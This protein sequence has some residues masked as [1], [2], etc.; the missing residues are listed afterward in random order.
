MSNK[1]VKT[2][3]DLKVIVKIPKKEIKDT[4]RNLS[5]QQLKNYNQLLHGKNAF[6]QEEWESLSKKQRWEIIQRQ[7]KVQKVLNWWKQRI[8]NSLC[9]YVLDIFQSKGCRPSM[10]EMFRGA[11][12]ATNFK[13]RL[14]FEQL[15]ITR[16]MIVEK[17]IEKKFIDKNLNILEG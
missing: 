3:D 4:Y 1:S 9:D 6:T 12:P 8:A 14:T 7:K 16:T 11:E 15:N 2:F 10:L 13:C 5:S 17:L